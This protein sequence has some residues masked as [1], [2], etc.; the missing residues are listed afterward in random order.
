MPQPMSTRASKD[1][2][3]LIPKERMRIGQRRHVLLYNVTPSVIALAT[4]AS[5][6]FVPIGL[7]E[8]G[9]LVC[10]WTL[11]GGLGISIGFHRY[12]THKSFD[13][14]RRFQ[15]VM[16]IAGSMA[17]QGPILYWVSVHRRHH[18]RSDTDGDPHSPRAISRG[19]RGRLVGFW[20]GHCGWVLGH[21]V[22]NPTVY[23]RDLL[24]IREIRWVDRYYQVWVW[25]GIFLPG[26]IGLLYTRSWAGGL[27]GSLWGGFL[28]IA[29][30]HHIIWGINSICHVYGS[31]PYSTR[32]KSRNNFWLS[33]P[34]F[35][36]G[37][38]N[39]HH[40]FP[41]A[42]NFGHRWWQLDP[43]YWALSV[44]QCLGLCWDVKRTDG[45]RKLPAVAGED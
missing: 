10:M 34:A 29:L 44:F 24:R 16:A 22:P 14:S 15:I 3:K 28:R 25:I 35:G 11:T 12:F 38:H 2:R 32:E 9:L 39:N 5:S 6:F 41:T 17:A 20:H 43:G 8:I 27:Q 30:G 21:D 13:T 4:I 31:Q 40:A 33:I 36:E 23:A 18:E 37:W 45:R 42:A 26:L 19:F 1:S 7:T